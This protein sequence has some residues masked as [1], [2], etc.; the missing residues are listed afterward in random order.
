MKYALIAAL[1]LFGFSAVA[2]TQTEVQKCDYTVMQNVSELGSFAMV[3]RKIDMNEYQAFGES[4]IEA[5][6]SSATCE[7]MDAKLILIGTDLAKKHYPDMP[8]DFR[9]P[10]G[11]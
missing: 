11:E 5:M 9:T 10:A 8:I 2:M 3:Q 1:S 4:L 6:Q 7:E